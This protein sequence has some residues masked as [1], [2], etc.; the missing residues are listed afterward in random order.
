MRQPSMVSDRIGFGCDAARLK[1][2]SSKRAPS[3]R[4]GTMPAPRAASA[5]A[6]T[7]SAGPLIVRWW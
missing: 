4:Q 1:M 7:T 3:T 2:S 6:V 5:K